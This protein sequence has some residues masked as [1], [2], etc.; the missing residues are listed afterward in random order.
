[1]VSKIETLPSAGILTEEESQLKKMRLL[2]STKGS[3]NLYIL[4]DEEDRTIVDCKYQ[5]VVNSLTL[6]S[7]ELTISALLGK[8]YEQA[9]RITPESLFK[10]MSEDKEMRIP[11]STMQE[12]LQ[13][14][15][16][17]FHEALHSITEMV[18]LVTPL[19]SESG[20][21]QEYPGWLS[22]DK[23]TKIAV[24]EEVFNKEIRPYVALDEGGVQI[25]DIVNDNELLIAY[26]GACTSCYSSIGS[27]LSAIQ[28]IVQ[29][30]IHKTLRVIP[31]V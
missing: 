22:L 19:P 17:A 23:E 15:C 29:D 10:T 9:R 11:F 21:S 3:I 14:I 24:I 27:T 18:E 1:M 2:K 8:T 13:L 20:E 7:L 5:A 16:D 26:Q 30:K 12:S 25:V 28:Q 31:K 6:G 4:I